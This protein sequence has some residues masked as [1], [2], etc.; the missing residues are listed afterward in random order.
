MS[1]FCNFLTF[2]NDFLYKM[3]QRFFNFFH[4]FKRFVNNTTSAFESKGELVPWD[5]PIK[6]STRIS[7]SYSG[8]KGEHMGPTDKLR[9][10]FLYVFKNLYPSFRGDIV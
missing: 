3:T 5:R 2:L 4:F 6:I 1:H 7:R 8:C 9:V 10:L